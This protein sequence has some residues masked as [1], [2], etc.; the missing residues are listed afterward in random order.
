MILKYISISELRLTP[1]VLVDNIPYKEQVDNSA[2]KENKTQTCDTY[3]TS[4]NTKQWF[5]EVMKNM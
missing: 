4:K 5:V 1:D 2:G 3:T